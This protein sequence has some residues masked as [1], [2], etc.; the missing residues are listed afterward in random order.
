VPTLTVGGRVLRE[1]APRLY[2]LYRGEFRSLGEAVAGQPI[3]CAADDRHG[4]VLNVQR[5]GH[6]RYECHVDSNPLG[7]LLYVTTHPPGA[8]GELVVARRPQAHS[9]AEVDENCDVGRAGRSAAGPIAGLVFAQMLFTAENPAVFDPDAW[10][11]SLAVNLT[12]PHALIHGLREQ[13]TDGS[14][15]VVA[16]ST[17]AFAGS[18]VAPSYAASKAAVH[19]LV[20]THANNLGRR[21]VRVNAVAPGWISEA[22]DTDKV[23]GVAREL[24]PLGRLGTP[25]EVAGVVSFGVSGGLLQ[26]YLTVTETQ[27]RP[28]KEQIVADATENCAGS[29]WKALRGVADDRL[30]RLVEAGTGRDPAGRIHAC[31]LTVHRRGVERL[32]AGEELPVVEPG[33]R[34]TRRPHLPDLRGYYLSRDY[35]QRTD[36]DVLAEIGEGFI[37]FNGHVGLEDRFDPTGKTRGDRRAGDARVSG[38]HSDQPAARGHVSGRCRRGCECRSGPSSGPTRRRRCR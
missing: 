16:T 19:N 30:L 25:G 36:R 9:I 33:S 23:A 14:S 26:R 11:R 37:D 6:L 7:G 22:T 18:F 31:G 27:F 21:G 1:R 34:G 2:E 8:G 15:V 10:A 24:T 35:L 13:F 32:A 3:V 29:R 12:A 20:K 28:V 17:E 5:G 4:A 38:R